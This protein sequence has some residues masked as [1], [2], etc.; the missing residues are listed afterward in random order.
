MTQRTDQKPRI[1]PRKIKVNLKSL[2]RK[3]L[4]IIQKYINPP[5]PK[6]VLRMYYHKEQSSDSSS[7]DDH[8]DKLKKTRL[9]LKNYFRNRRIW[10]RLFQFTSR[11]FRVFC[12][13]LPR[14]KDLES[15]DVE[16]P[17]PRQILSERFKKY[18]EIRNAV[19]CQDLYDLMTPIPR[20]VILYF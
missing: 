16:P 11:I 15:K 7:D 13:N 19:S 14:S 2:S 17:L 12:R 3:D 20:R 8:V 6:D 1:G 18:F 10:H 5:I 4:E 9:L